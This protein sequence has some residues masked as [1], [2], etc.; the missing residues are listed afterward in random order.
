M[1][2]ELQTQQSEELVRIPAHLHKYVGDRSGKEAVEKDDLLIPRLAVAQEGNTPQLKKTNE[3]F[4]PGLE[5]GQLFNTVTSE[6]YGS[7]VTV[8]PLFFFKNYI[9]FIPMD[10]GG[11]VKAMYENKAEVPPADLK[12]TDGPPKVTEFK[13]RMCLVKNKQGRLEPIVVGF[14]S[15]GLKFAR[16][17]NSLIQLVNLPAFAREYNL[18]VVQMSKGA[19]SWFGINPFPAGF[20]HER[21]FAEAK[22]YFDSLQEQGYKVDTTGIDAEAAAPEE[23]DTSFDAA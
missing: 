17:W 11:G 15:T 7:E 5:A 9:E 10:E 16:K 8:I 1:T 13:N 6:I 19:L 4:I 20:V 21:L 23:G 3:L 2:T 12:W 18:K 14:K 22:G